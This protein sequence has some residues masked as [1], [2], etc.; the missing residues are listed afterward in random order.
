MRTPSRPS[1]LERPRFEPQAAL[2]LAAVN[3]SSS[4]PTTA[5]S[6]A[7]AALSTVK[8]KRDTFLPVQGTTEAAVAVAVAVTVPS[9]AAVVVDAQPVVVAA[10]TAS[11]GGKKKGKK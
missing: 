4:I 6:V 5:P 7:T 1:R 8:S 10:A 9:A 11:K 3:P 2:S